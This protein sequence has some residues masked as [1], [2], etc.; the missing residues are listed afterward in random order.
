MAN[1]LN[2]DKR[3]ANFDVRS[4]DQYR[5]LIKQRYEKA[6]YRKNQDNPFLICRLD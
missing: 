4:S 5:E 6:K 1:H 2:R 3:E